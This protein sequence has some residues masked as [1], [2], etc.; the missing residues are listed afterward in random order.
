MPRLVV[1]N[2]VSL[3]GV[4]QAPAS[5][6]EDRRGGFGHGGWAARNADAVMG[7]V[8]GRRSGADSAL[9]IGRRTYEDLGAYWPHA[10][11]DNPYTEVINRRRKWVVSTT[12]REPLEWQNSRLLQGDAADAVA[13]LKREQGPDLTI[14]GSGELVR[15][16]LPH[17]L[18]DA[19]VLMI[20][21]I[22]LGTGV[23]LFERDGAF[24]AFRLADSIAT[25]TGVIIATYE[26]KV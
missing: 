5:P 23:R 22:V 13:R 9:V 20:H 25:T 11:A 4:M 12:L 8:L 16:L 17:G 26:S 2:H 6:D 14:L 3:D 10:P 21:P 1:L 19:V 15:S 24:A 18:I 7:E